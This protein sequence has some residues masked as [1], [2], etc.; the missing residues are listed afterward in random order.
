MKQFI[1]TVK[2]DAGIIKFRVI[3]SNENETKKQVCKAENCPES[4]IIKV[5]RAAYNRI[6]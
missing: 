5:R 3:A 4:A 2:H 1:V 6:S